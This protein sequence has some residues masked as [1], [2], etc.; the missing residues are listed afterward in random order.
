MWI[1]QLKCIKCGEIFTENEKPRIDQEKINIGYG[2]VIKI[3]NH[4]RK[5]GHK[6]LQFNFLW[7]PGKLLEISQ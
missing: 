6:V 3:L 7:N 2:T 5:R 4:Q 1:E